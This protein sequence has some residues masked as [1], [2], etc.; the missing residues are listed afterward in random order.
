M[1]DLPM[2]ALTLHLTGQGAE[3]WVLHE[4]LSTKVTGMVGR[5]TD[6]R[7]DWTQ[8]LPAKRGRA[9]GL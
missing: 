8:A 2:N 1:R 6:R 3:A 4:A 7:T 9:D 5:S